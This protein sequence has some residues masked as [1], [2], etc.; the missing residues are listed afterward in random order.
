[1]AFK[2]KEA[3]IVLNS[4]AIPDH[5]KKVYVTLP[6]D[7]RKTISKFLLNTYVDSKNRWEELSNLYFYG[8]D[9][10]GGG[11]LQT[12]QLFAEVFINL[13]GAQLVKD[14]LS[15]LKAPAEVITLYD[16]LPEDEKA[17]IAY[18]LLLAY[19]HLNDARITDT[20]SEMVTSKNNFSPQ[21]IELFKRVL[22]DAEDATI[23]GINSYLED[24]KKHVNNGSMPQERF[25]EIKA[26]MELEK[27][28]KLK[29]LR[30]IRETPA[31]VSYEKAF[32][33]GIEE[34]IKKQE[35][36]DAAVTVKVEHQGIIE[37][38]TRDNTI[39]AIRHALN[40]L[41]QTLAELGLSPEQVVEFRGKLHEVT[42]VLVSE[43]EWQKEGYGDDAIG[44]CRPGSDTI[45]LRISDESREFA[46]AQMYGSVVHEILHH[47][48]ECYSNNSSS[49][50]LHET[51]TE[52]F[53][54]LV[55]AK[56][57]GLPTEFRLREKPGEAMPSK[58]F[59]VSSIVDFS[60]PSY[61]SLVMNDE[62]NELFAVIGRLEWQKA[63]F[64]GDYKEVKR[65][66]NLYLPKNEDAFAY[67]FGDSNIEESIAAALKDLKPNDPLDWTKKFDEAKRPYVV[68]K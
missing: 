28:P 33:A 55:I 1:M 37:G 63:Y 24:I 51:L 53:A 13:N 20:I 25:L 43:E 17:I 56:E 21:A 49:M 30:K 15:K 57:L 48:T 9:R 16:K 58:R 35:R 67:L 26:D 42:F 47:L 29:W 52:V 39:K 34:V 46:L 32:T 60:N 66:V 62:F 11:S 27:G 6:E 2:Q 7:E 65:Q 40:S 5:I 36:T 44:L 45:L 50:S 12:K 64:S 22:K 38:Q 54:N 4:S 61:H 19:Q 18:H 31:G 14:E 68:R 41:P 10:P 23:A 3:D 59:E 8:I